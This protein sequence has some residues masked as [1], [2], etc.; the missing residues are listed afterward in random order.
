MAPVQPECVML[1]KVPFCDLLYCLPGLRGRHH[2]PVVYH[3][4]GEDRHNCLPQSIINKATITG[5]AMIEG[6]R[7]RKDGSKFWASI[8]VHRLLVLS[9]CTGSI[10]QL[11]PLPTID[12]NHHFFLTFHIVLPSGW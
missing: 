10:L 9:A 2:N 5:K 4:V 6:W 7:L 3:L 8:V 1:L 12:L 11:I